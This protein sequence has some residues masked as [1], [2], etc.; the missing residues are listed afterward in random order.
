MTWWWNSSGWSEG[1]YFGRVLSNGPD[2][3][4]RSLVLFSLLASGCGSDS[5]PTSSSLVESQS[6]TFSNKA[7]L[8]EGE[9]ARN[10]S[11][12]AN[13]S[14]QQLISYLESNPTG[15]LDTGTVGQDLLPFYC[16][17]PVQFRLTTKAPHL[18]G[19]RILD[20]QGQVVA[21]WGQGTRDLSLEAGDYRLELNSAL[22][23][24]AHIFW[25]SQTP[26]T[27]RPLTS[28]ASPGVYIAELSE[29][30]DFPLVRV[31]STLVGVS[32]D[33]SSTLVQA[34][35]LAELVELKTRPGT[36]L[37]LGVQ[38]Y[39]ANGGTVVNVLTCASLSAADLSSALSTLPDA[40]SSYQLA[41][42]D[43]YSLPVADADPLAQTA[44]SWANQNNSLLFLDIPRSVNTSSE[45]VIWRQQRPQLT[46]SN[47]LLY[48]PGLAL[49]SGPS[50]GSS[51]S[52]LGLL[53]QLA[54]HSAPG[55][56]PLGE[57]LQG[58][59]SP[60]V[61]YDLLEVANLGAAQINPV[62]PDLTVSPGQLLLS[63]PSIPDL[64]AQQ[65]L[66]TI[67]QSIKACMNQFVFSPNTANTWQI[68][69][70]AVSNGMQELYQLGVLAGA[71]SGQAYSFACGLGQTMTEQ[72]ILNGYL[73]LSGLVLLN[74]G[75]PPVE[76]N[77]TQW[78]QTS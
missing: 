23:G 26:E 68:L 70:E 12:R 10:S 2:M 44:L 11:L 9:L 18:A 52:V 46:S 33:G 49:E 38:Q 31:V 71:S 15:S 65:R 17:Q 62:R 48:W 29:D 27:I 37:M 67:T 72:D 42:T 30:P 5:S 74:A 47:G 39:F 34:N 16:P 57:K 69:V 8:H 56:V 41:L 1:K 6:L 61:A 54:S 63:Q 55:A 20:S 64:S 45:A 73:I 28:L 13:L 35:T 51:A 4:I 25:R 77:F 53:D 40:L 50:V 75:L 32:S 22:A 66:L 43:L 19:A 3:Q 7:S 14:R 78:L 36:N 60:A 76:L 59:Q 58:A 24:D 21:S